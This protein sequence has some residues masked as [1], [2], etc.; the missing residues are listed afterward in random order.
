[1]RRLYDRFPNKTIQRDDL[2]SLYREWADLGLCFIATMVWGGI[3]TT[4]QQRLQNLLTVPEKAMAER[5]RKT[6]LLIK[7]GLYPL[8]FI[9]WSRGGE[10]NIDGISYSFFSKIFF[11][12]GQSMRSLKEKPL[13]LDKWTCNAFFVLFTQTVG[14]AVSKELFYIPS[15]EGFEKYRMVYPKT[16]NNAFVYTLY[17][18]HMN[19]WADAL[20]IFPGQ[21]EQFLFGVDLRRDN[22]Q[23]NPRNEFSKMILDVIE[24]RHQPEAE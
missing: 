17:V 11:F 4:K 19:Y 5:M 18:K 9:S 7:R 20:K 1:M 2:I 6:K 22:S 24:Q 8:A 14:L 13:I 15:R 12:I 23:T 16:G 21:L 3:D 10:N